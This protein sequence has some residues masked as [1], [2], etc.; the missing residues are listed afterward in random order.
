MKTIQ[1]V[2]QKMAAG[3]YDARVQNKSN[4]EIGQLG[5]S[6]ND[7]AES[8]QK[9]TTEMA[10]TSSLVENAPSISCTLIGISRSNT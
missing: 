4:D 8:I 6:F 3:D 2:A 7:M 10:R 5:Q 1:D 9:N